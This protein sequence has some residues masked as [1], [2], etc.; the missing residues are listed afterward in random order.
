MF[1]GPTVKFARH[2]VEMVVVMFAGMFVLGAAALLPLFAAGVTIDELRAE[3]PALILLGMGLTM[4]APMYWW[5]ERRGHSRAASVAMA[6][7][8]II[9]ALAL[10]LLL[11]SGAQTDLHAL[12]MIEHTVMF[13]AMLLAM[14]PYRAEFTHAHG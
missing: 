6:A 3:A 11:A 5:M 13:P 9:P 4:A 2:Y 1:D 8:M 12:L 14:L 10:V 7:S